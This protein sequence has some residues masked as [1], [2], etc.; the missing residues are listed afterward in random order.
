MAVAGLVQRF[1]VLA[2]KVEQAVS[3]EVAVLGMVEAV[4]ALADLAEAVPQGEEA[5]AWEA[6]FL[7]AKGPH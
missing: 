3:A 1:L 7:S 6:L 5:R 4:P 2:I